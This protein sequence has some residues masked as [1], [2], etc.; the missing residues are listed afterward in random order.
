MTCTG[1][2]NGQ[3]T[4]ASSWPGGTTAQGTMH[5][6]G[7]MQTGAN[8]IPVEYTVQTTSTYKGP[9]CGSVKPL[10]MPASN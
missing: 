2:M 8:A 4:L 7:T 9:D 10:P 6:T 3:A 5:F 1:K